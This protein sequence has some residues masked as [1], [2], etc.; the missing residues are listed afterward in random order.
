[1][2][3]ATRIV[4][5]IQGGALRSVYGDK[6]PEGVEIEV[7]LRDQDNIEAGDADPMGA[8]YEPETHY[9]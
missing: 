6:L 5:D 9:W 1:M 4:I 8:D 2:S 3:E 7:I